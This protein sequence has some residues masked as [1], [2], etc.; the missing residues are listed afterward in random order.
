MKPNHIF[1]SQ[2][3]LLLTMTALLF[4]VCIEV[5]HHPLKKYHIPLI[6]WIVSVSEYRQASNGYLQ[7]IDG[8]V[9]PSQQYFATQQ[10]QLL[11]NKLRTKTFGLVGRHAT[12]LSL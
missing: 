2:R 5:T 6:G 3:V 10:R 12:S 9:N 11:H 4:V 1:T 8:R 7:A